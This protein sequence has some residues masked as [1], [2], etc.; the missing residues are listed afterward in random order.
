MHLKSDDHIGIPNGGQAVSD[1]NRGD[2]L[3][4]VDLI[5]SRL[6]KDFYN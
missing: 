5:Q 4:G 3:L 6:G 1:N 2:V